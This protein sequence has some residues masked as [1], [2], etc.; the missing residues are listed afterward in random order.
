M[1]HEISSAE[2]YTAV[3]AD[4]GNAHCPKCV[5]NVYLRVQSLLLASHSRTVL[6]TAWLLRYLIA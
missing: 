5:P 1:H 3:Q 4:G 6:A 2:K